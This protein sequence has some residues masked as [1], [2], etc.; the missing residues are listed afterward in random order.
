MLLVLLVA[1][2][3]PARRDPRVEAI[4]QRI[5]PAPMYATVAKLVGFGTRHT[6]SETASDAR[7]IGAARRWLAAEFAAA[8]KE[9]G[10]R[11]QPFEDRFVAVAGEEQGLVGST[12]LARRLADE[13]VRVLAMTSIDI[14]G[15][16]EGQDG[17]KDDVTARLF[18]EG[19][20]SAETEAERRLREALGGENDGAAREWARYVKRVGEQYVDHLDLLVM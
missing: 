3:A 14:A 1:A 19:V 17:V 13:G 20:S 16:T 18:C 9:P 2:L 7:G 12:H 8:A 15:N 10:S 6:L 4:V 5:E 11:L